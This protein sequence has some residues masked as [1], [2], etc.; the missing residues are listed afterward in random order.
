MK[1]QNLPPKTGLKHLRLLHDNAPVH[2][3]TLWPWPIFLSPRRSP[4]Y[5]ILYLVPPPPRLPPFYHFLFPK[6]K[7]HLTVNRYNLRNALGSTVYQYLMGIPIEEHT[8][9]F[10]KWTD[11]LKKVYSGRWRVF[12]RAGQVKMILTFAVK[13]KQWKWHYFWNS[14]IYGL[15]MLNR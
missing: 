6:L 5:H 12:W 4:S 10:K 3:A 8:N 13:D 15:Y 9:C 1:F 7:Y 2:K 14:P 11:R